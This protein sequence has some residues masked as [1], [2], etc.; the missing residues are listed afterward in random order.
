MKYHIYLL[1]LVL[2]NVFN[3]FPIPFRTASISIFLSLAVSLYASRFRVWLCVAYY[4]FYYTHLMYSTKA[5]VLLTASC[6]AALSRRRASNCLPHKRRVHYILV[7][8]HKLFVSTY[9]I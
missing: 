3:L 2:R 6:L 1:K 8:V 9:T 4:M 7:V 5:T